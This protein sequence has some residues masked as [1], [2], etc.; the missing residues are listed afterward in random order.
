M[1]DSTTQYDSEP[2]SH[3][4]SYGQRG[5]W[6]IYQIAPDNAAY[7][8]AFAARIRSRLD[9]PAFRRTFQKLVDRHEMLRTTYHTDGGTPFQRIHEHLALSIEVQDASEWCEEGL[10]ERV[11]KAYEH[12]SIWK[13]GRPC[14]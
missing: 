2:T 10:Q 3:P 1:N 9:L 13:W 6:W 11:V 4:L 5:L 7:N 14:R 12:K 8:C